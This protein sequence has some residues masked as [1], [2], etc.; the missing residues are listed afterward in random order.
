MRCFY[1]A[2]VLVRMGFGHH[3]GAFD[4]LQALSAFH[5]CAFLF[6]DCL[7]RGD[8]LLAGCQ[9]F[10]FVAVYVQSRVSL[11]LTRNH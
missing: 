5:A 10:G 3:S 7:A 1:K 6:R 4:E 9:V 2:S 11:T 8:E